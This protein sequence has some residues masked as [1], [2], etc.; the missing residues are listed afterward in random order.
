MPLL[1]VNVT[2]GLHSHPSR[3]SSRR[4]P[5]C[6]QCGETIRAT[7]IIM[8]KTALIL[9]CL[10]PQHVELNQALAVAVA[11]RHDDSESLWL[12]G[13][14]LFAD[15]PTDIAEQGN[16]Q[17]ASLVDFFVKALRPTICSLRFYS[18]VDMLRF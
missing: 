18:D 2:A 9:S 12:A 13:E 6:R 16:S 8:M 1:V 7:I 5:V 11:L 10:A 3:Q 4:V 15:V 14:P 17:I